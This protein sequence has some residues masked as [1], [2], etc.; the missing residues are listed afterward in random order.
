MQL[1]ERQVKEQEA[2]VNLKSLELQTINDMSK[3]Q[4]KKK[5]DDKI[6]SAIFL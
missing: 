1:L 4:Q 2:I 3:K 5:A 6:A